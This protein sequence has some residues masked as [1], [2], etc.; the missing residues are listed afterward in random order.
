[1]SDASTVAVIRP[2]ANVVI[3]VGPASSTPEPFPAPAGQQ[4]QVFGGD[5][6]G[7]FG[8]ALDDLV[9]PTGQTFGAFPSRW[10]MPDGAG[11][12][13]LVEL[14]DGVS[15][16]LGTMDYTNNELNPTMLETSLLTWSPGPGLESIPV[17]TSPTATFPDGCLAP[18]HPSG[19]TGNTLDSVVPV[20]IDGVDYI[21]AVS[22]VTYEGW[23]LEIYGEPYAMIVFKKTAGVWAFDPTRSMNAGQLHASSAAGA[24]A[25]A[26]VGTNDFPD[27]PTFYI[28]PGLGPMVKAP[29][30]GHLI[31]GTYFHATTNSGTL[32]AIDPVAGVVTAFY[33]IPDITDVNDVEL[34]YSARNIEVNPYS[35]SGDER[36]ILTPDVF[37]RSN[38]DLYGLHPLTEFAYTGSAFTVESLPMT[39][40]TVPNIGYELSYNLCAY[41]ADQNLWCPTHGGGGVGVFNSHECHFFEASASTLPTM[42]DGRGGGDGFTGGVFPTV[43][44]SDFRYG[45]FAQPGGNE[46]SVNYDAVNDHIIVVGGNGILVGAKLAESLE[47]GSELCVNG[48]MH[49]FT[50]TSTLT[51]GSPSGTSLDVSGLTDTIA[52]G[53]PVTVFDAAGNTQAFTLT[54]E[55]NSG[56][57]AISISSVG[58][59]LNTGSGYTAFWGWNGFFDSTLDP[60]ADSDFT[61]GRCLE[62]TS[63]NG[64]SNF[65][66]QIPIDVPPGQNC[67]LTGHFKGVT[68]VQKLT[69]QLWWDDG[70]GNLLSATSAPVITEPATGELFSF[71]CL[72]SPFQGSSKGVVFLNFTASA[73]GDKQRLGDVSLKYA[74]AVATTKVDTNKARLYNGGSIGKGDFVNG[75]LCFGL[76]QTTPGYPLNIGTSVPQWLISVD[77]AALVTPDPAT[78]PDAP[79][80]TA[81]GGGDG[82]VSPVW[83]AP[84]SDGGSPILSYNINLGPTSGSETPAMTGIS[85]N[86]LTDTI[87]GLTNFV[88]VFLTVTAVNAIGPSAP[89]NELFVT[90]AAV[91]PGAPVLAVTPGN[92]ENAL[93]WSA[94]TVGQP[95]TGVEVWSGPTSGS[96]TLQSMLGNV[97]TFSDT[98]LPNSTERFYGLKY[99]NAAGTGPMSNVVGATPEATPTMVVPPAVSG[100]AA[101]VAGASALASWTNN[102]SVGANDP[103]LGNDFYVDGVQ[104]GYYGYPN[105]PE[106]SYEFLGLSVGP[107]TLGVAPYNSAGV[108]TL[109]TVSVTITAAPATSILKGI[110]AG[111][112]SADESLA[113]T[114]GISPLE[115]YSDYPDGTNYGTI[116]DYSPPSLPS[117][118]VISLGLNMCANGTNLSSVAGNIGTYTTLAKRL[119]NGTIIRLGYE[120]DINTG[121]WGPANNTPAEYVA[122]W[123]LIHD[124]M[125]AVNSSFIWD[126]CCNSGTSTAEQLMAWYPGDAY[127]DLIGFDHYDPG[128]GSWSQGLA[129]ITVA[130]QRG[131]KVS[132]GEWGLKNSK[133]DP[134]F[135]NNG[136]K[137]F[138]GE[139]A[140]APAYEVYYHSYFSLTSYGSNLTT[141]PNSLAAYKADAAEEETLRELV[142]A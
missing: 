62:I 21:F 140:G 127:V 45:S 78:V 95:F 121:P 70:D 84:A 6:A 119:P 104:V 61:S 33:Q 10:Q 75:R 88:E 77:P 111:N 42:E 48:D 125:M 112:L 65:A 134:T 3:V 101:M 34:S 41:D 85:P 115:V 27:D 80:L 64:T 131:K 68:N 31:I 43:T 83:T 105:A 107:H 106:V 1:M 114:L 39:P 142:S 139:L 15:A 72:A 58:V 53:T 122:A 73:V 118:C 129:A 44:K 19:A 128:D 69:A 9:T 56:D 63:T 91:L 99:Q 13:F 89:S 124:A 20:T 74:P 35:E 135:I 23:Q 57:A 60:V 117:G 100:L 133:D 103:T 32:V 40:F 29:A 87:T 7:D 26:V 17:P 16:A 47:L 55:A 67:I 137:V 2:A 54:A 136:F 138:A 130:S 113:S 50:V 76:L 132:I 123:K 12:F 93:D 22:P 110:Y 8:Q 52:S 11:P 25:F 92:A 82:Q 5:G 24:D 4:V 97:L 116:A 30:T 98:G 141:A 51:H 120:F 126:W 109:K 14:Q 81:P 37:V 90:P 66:A 36:F 79:T 59:T 108:G 18:P 96:L 38:G 49:V 94:P 28:N 86:A 46:G 102:G 71:Q